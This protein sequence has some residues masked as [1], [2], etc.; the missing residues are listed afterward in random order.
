[1]TGIGDCVQDL[2]EFLV[3]FHS[4]RNNEFFNSIDPKQ[5]VE[6]HENLTP[7]ATLPGQENADTK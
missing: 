2:F 4:P 5:P 7:S 6:N 1:L 3:D